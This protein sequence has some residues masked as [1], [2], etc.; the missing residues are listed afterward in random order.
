MFFKIHK[1]AFTFLAVI[2]VFLNT[3]CAS[4][5]IEQR[6]NRAILGQNNTVP[7]VIQPL[8]HVITYL[9]S[10]VMYSFSQLNKLVGLL[11]KWRSGWS[12][13]RQQLLPR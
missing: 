9:I 8:S 4:R 3:A 10:L 13:N 1:R 7:D 5:K 12:T 2:H 11:T 6:Y